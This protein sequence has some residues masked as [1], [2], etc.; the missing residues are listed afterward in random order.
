MKYFI[1]LLAL[2]AISSLSADYSGCASGSCQYRGGYGGGQQYA[3]P[4]ARNYDNMNRSS[5]RSDEMNNP[6]NFQQR[7]RD[8]FQPRN[9]DNSSQN[10]DSM[11][12]GSMNMT[13]P[14]DTYRAGD[15]VMRSDNTMTQRSDTIQDVGYTAQDEQLNA[16]LRDRLRNWLSTK[17]LEAIIIKTQNGNVVLL[18]TIEKDEDVRNISEKLKNI[19]GVRR[20]DNQLKSK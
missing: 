13:D 19:D 14:H 2:T 4:Q 11:Q 15:L 18:G 17:D 16:K 12:Q 3:R 8:N 7:N 6:D 1:T 9:M 10:M 20:I 5:G